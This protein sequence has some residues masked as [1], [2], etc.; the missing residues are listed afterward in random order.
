VDQQRKLLGEVWKLLASAL[1]RFRELD[2]R[3]EVTETEVQVATRAY[4][5]DRMRAWRDAD[6]FRPGDPRPCL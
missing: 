5:R 4:L 6:I 1:E 3:L 2:K